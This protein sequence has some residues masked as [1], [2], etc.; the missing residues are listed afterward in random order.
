MSLS[1]SINTIETH[2]S[3]A[4]EHTEALLQGKKASASKSR[5]SLQNITKEAK[6]LRKN[7][8]EYVKTIPV[9]TR[10][11]LEVSNKLEKSEKEEPLKV[12]ELEVSNKLEK[13]EEPELNREY[14]HV[15]SS[16][17]TAVKKP[18]KSV[19]KKPA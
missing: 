8:S 11:K 3:S 15:S 14:P 18:R 16:T 4:K 19:A 6:Q 2:L 13:S 10:A 12:V 7:I 1:S 9:K 17:K 5:A